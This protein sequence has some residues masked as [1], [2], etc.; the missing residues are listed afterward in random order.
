LLAVMAV[1]IVM[2]AYQFVGDHP[3]VWGY[4]PPRFHEGLAM[5]VVILA[6]LSALAFAVD[7]IFRRKARRRAVVGQN[8]D[9]STQADLV[10]K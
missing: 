8:D 5:I 6:P 9:H 4:K 10:S 7:R 2:W 3:D 1:L